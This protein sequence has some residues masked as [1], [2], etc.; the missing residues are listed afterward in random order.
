MMAPTEVLARQHYATITRMLEEHQIPVKA[1]L[2]T[3]SMTTKEKR[4]PMTGSSA[5]MRRSSWEPMR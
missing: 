3:G 1:E 4:R 2:L 5:A